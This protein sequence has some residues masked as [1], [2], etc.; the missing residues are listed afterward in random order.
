MNEI[1][2]Y[3][4]FLEKLA[5]LSAET[6]VYIETFGDAHYDPELTVEQGV[7]TKTLPTVWLSW[8]EDRMKYVG[9]TDNPYDGDVI[10]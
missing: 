1:D 2:K 10:S 7:Y 8:D 4:D 3:I 5:A 6:G 9:K